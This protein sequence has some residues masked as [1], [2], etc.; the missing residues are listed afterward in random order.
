MMDA[1][2]NSWNP[3]GASASK[4]LPH[5]TEA[6]QAVLGGMM[7]DADVCLDVKLRLTPDDFFH[8]QHRV[9]YE[10]VLALMGAGI[11][12]DVTTVTARIH[13]YGRLEEAGGVDYILAVFESVTTIAHT[14]HYVDLVLEKSISR[15][16]IEKARFLIDQGYNPE[17]T[18]GDLI[19]EARRQFA[20]LES[21]AKDEDF[22]RIENIIA[23]FIK[24]IEHLSKQDGEITGL[25]TGYD[26][27]DKM[28][29]GL[30]RNDLIIVAARPAM[31]KTAFALNVAQNVAKFNDN[32]KVAIFSLEMGAQQLV[33]RLISAEGRI[34][35][36][37]LRTGSLDGDDWRSLKIATNTLSDLGI[38]IDDTPGLK[39]SQVRAKCRQLHK[40]HGLDLVLIDYLQLLSGSG[41]NGSNRQQEVS[42]ISRTLKEVARELEIPVIALSQLSRQVESR[43]DKR[44]MM[45]DLRESGSIEQDADIVTFLFREDYYNKDAEAN[46][47]FVEII[48]AKH[49]NGSVGSIKLAFRKE[50]SRFENL[51]WANEEDIPPE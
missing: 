49:R 35:S 43:E 4:N 1:G 33:A 40:Q 36:Y 12:V 42:E 22:Q 25:R 16:V 5:N 31:G 47:N 26:A 7:R 2:N 45:S 24:N 23:E 10:V 32:A 18:A 46:N 28:T 13:D 50:I 17:L 29:S 48:F 21:G 6:E 39:I 14:S 38:F 37:K 19:E 3:S 11:A 20:N 51:I 8:H 27:L 15:K 41:G 34:D 44:P 30:Q 9:I